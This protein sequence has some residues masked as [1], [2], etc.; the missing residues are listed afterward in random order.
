M[1]D[2]Q[3]DGL[4][5]QVYELISK[6]CDLACSDSFPHFETKLL[7]NGR[8]ECRIAI[9]GV[10][11]SA[12]ASGKTEVESINVCALGMLAILK[13]D[14]D[15]NQYD[16]DIED[17]IFGDSIGQFF[18]VDYDKECRYHLCETDIHL[19]QND[20]YAYK[21]LENYASETISRIKEGGGEIDLM[22]DIVTIRLL[23]KERKK[24]YC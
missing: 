24:N 12:K 18:N 13:R 2:F 9:P 11:K 17:N 7:E 16:P 21:L 5:H 8:W 10:K 14:H 22:S 23:V 6:M 19:N 4:E 3:N 1:I 15:K 20:T